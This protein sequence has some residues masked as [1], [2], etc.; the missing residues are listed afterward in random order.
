MLFEDLRSLAVVKHLRIEKLEAV[1]KVLEEKLNKELEL[2][3][4]YFRLL[5]EK[6]N[7][8]EKLTENYEEKSR[9][10]VLEIKIHCELKI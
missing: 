7:Q 10:L 5:T 8:Y 3:N 4:K 9:L 2:K 6:E 1:E